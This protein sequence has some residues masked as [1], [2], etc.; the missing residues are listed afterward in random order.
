M[1]NEEPF[2]AAAGRRDL[3]CRRFIAPARGGRC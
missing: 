2:A 3:G 1:G